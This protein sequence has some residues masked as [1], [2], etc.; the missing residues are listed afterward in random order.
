MR[1]VMSGYGRLRLYLA[2]DHPACV[3]YDRALGCLYKLTALER[4]PLYPAGTPAGATG[5]RRRER[6]GAREAV[7][8]G[9]RRGARGVLRSLPVR[10]RHMN[11]H[12][13]PGIAQIGPDRT[14]S[15]RPLQ[16][17]LTAGDSA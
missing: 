7:V 4:A 15:T 11:G 12:P 14:R 9:A 17:T 10:T 5:V 1:A 16:S 2:A 13:G 6:G 3:A 8:G